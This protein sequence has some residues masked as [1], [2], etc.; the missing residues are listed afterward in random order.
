MRTILFQLLPGLAAASI[1][2][3]PMPAIAAGG[4]HG[5][6]DAIVETPGACH[7]ESWTSDLGGGERLVNFSPACTSRDLPAVEIG[8][9]LQREGLR[10]ERRWLAGPA[11]KWT[12]NGGGG[13][14]AVGLTA[15]ALIDSGSGHLA[16]AALLVPVTFR[17]TEKVT[18]N[19]NAGVGY[20]RG[21]GGHILY[22]T[23]FEV[24]ATKG[25]TLMAEIFGQPD[26]QP[27]LQ[28]GVR[29]TFD[30]DRI[31]LDLLVGRQNEG[32]GNGSLTLGFTIR[33]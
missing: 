6:D 31:D 7:L 25:V 22:G 29:W 10:G 18:V 33:R 4:A 23:Q 17:P 13:G 1:I 8:G 2:A 27:F 3:M 32:T 19:L 21:E 28:A 5:V 9:S 12:L 15:S 20:G 30:R 11:V 24:A 16:S 26:R 14:P